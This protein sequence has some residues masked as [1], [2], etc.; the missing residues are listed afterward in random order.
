MKSR[1][2]VI[3]GT[4]VFAAAGARASTVYFPAMPGTPGTS[5]DN[6]TSGKCLFSYA[7]VPGA[8]TGEM[9]TSWSF[10]ALNG[11]PVA[12]SFLIRAGG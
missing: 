12:L 1:V 10:Y 4:L 9:L 11:T 8:V 3:L 7:A 5:N 2:F 6:C